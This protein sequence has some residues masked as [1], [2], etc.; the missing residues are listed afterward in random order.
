MND[1][2][3]EFFADDCLTPEDAQKRSSKSSQ[4]AD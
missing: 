3:A 1:L 4:N 2:F